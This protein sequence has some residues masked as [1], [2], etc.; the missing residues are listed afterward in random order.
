MRIDYDDLREDLMAN[1][2]GEHGRG[3]FGGSLLE[4]W[5]LEAASPQELRDLAENAGFDINDYRF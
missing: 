2:M 3:A 5:E 1:E 4:P